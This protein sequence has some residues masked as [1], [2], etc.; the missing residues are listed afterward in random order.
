MLSR[1]R[2][3]TRIQSHD[4]FALST[5]QHFCRRPPPVCCRWNHNATSAAPPESIAFEVSDFVE[6][7]KNGV[8]AQPVPEVPSYPRWQ[9]QDRL[10]TI[11][12]V[13]VEPGV[14]VPLHDFAK[15]QQHALNPP[16][17]S[18][19][20]SQIF[21]VAGR[22]HAI[23]RSGAHLAFV[24]IVNRS[25]IGTRHVTK[26]VLSS[27]DVV[28]QI[29]FNRKQL[30]AK[31]TE[32]HIA[33]A[34]GRLRR[35]D[36]IYVHGVRA[37][38]AKDEDKVQLVARD[39]PVVLTTSQQPPPEKKDPKHRDT[40]K[41]FTA[42]RHVEMLTWPAMTIPVEVRSIIL[43][44]LRK[45][46]VEHD[47][48]E[49]QTPILSAHAG[50]AT[51]RPF[52]TS[53]QEF[54]DRKIALRV[55]PELW[56][57][58]LIVGGMNRVFEIGPCFRNEGLDRTHNPEFTTC[59]FY[60]TYLDIDRLM[61]YTELILGKVAMAVY[62]RYSRKRGTPTPYIDYDTLDIFSQSASGKWGGSLG[63][64]WR[65]RYPRIDFVLGINERLHTPLP[66]LA[67]STA[68]DEIL[69]ICEHHSIP[70]PHPPTLPRLLDKLSPTFSNRNALSF[71]HPTAPNDQ[72]VAARAELFFNGK[73]LVNCYEEENSPIEQRRKFMD[74]QRY[75]RDPAD[76]KVVD[77]EA[78]KV[79]EDYIRALEYGMPPTGGWGCG[80]DR[81][82]MLMTGMDRIGDVLSFGS[83]RA[84]TRGAEKWE[85]AA[86]HGQIVGEEAA[87]IA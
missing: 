14:N 18:K 64:S 5:A 19:E 82:V 17:D 36:H 27:G 20:G 86:A 42:G 4:L 13:Q 38:H 37:T 67:S 78:M 11:A 76:D 16:E 41:E 1:L 32:E 74:Q 73:E 29:Q 31:Y 84:V 55:A 35:N 58:R 69:A 33:H 44:S 63:N 85:K 47:F 23:R 10:N 15:I 65:A 3:R 46:L 51:A 53:A 25:S 8:E 71:I 66:N 45:H 28:L 50:G 77:D 72:P 52:I 61:Y 34:F 75:S 22:V 83:L 49:V 59:E 7:A 40:D 43:T 26:D 39:L 2:W 70:I 9:A 60:A 62:S 21:R 56:L 24:D 54:P 30:A 6:N 57:K 48:I 12:Q 79:D 87:P 80:I 68:R 81:L